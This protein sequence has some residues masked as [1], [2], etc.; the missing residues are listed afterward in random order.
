[1]RV[2]TLCMVA[3][4][5]HSRARK[6]EAVAAAAGRRV[7]ELYRWLGEFAPG[8]SGVG[9]ETMTDIFRRVTGRTVGFTAVG[10]SAMVPLAL[11]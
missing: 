4:D 1:M 8:G 3:K 11:G 2:S 9:G 10:D 7:V 6:Q 5:K